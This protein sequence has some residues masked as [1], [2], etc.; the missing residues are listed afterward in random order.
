M[1]TFAQNEELA[2]FAEIYDNEASRPHKVDITTTITTDEGKVVFKKDD[3]RDS[4]ELAGK[5]GAYLYPTRIPLK[6]LVP[7]SYVLQVAAGSRLGGIAAERQVRIGI[8]AAPVGS[9]RQ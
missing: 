4:S 3:V 2:L 5:R 1:R 8:V 9:N 7:G 6:D